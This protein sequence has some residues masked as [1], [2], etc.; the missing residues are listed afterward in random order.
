MLNTTILPTLPVP[1]IDLSMTL[2]VI[3]KLQY[4]FK[5]DTDIEVHHKT[6]P[7]SVNIIDYYYYTILQKAETVTEFGLRRSLGSSLIICLLMCSVLCTVKYSVRTD[8]QIGVVFS[9][10]ID[11]L[12]L[13]WD[14]VYSELL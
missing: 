9:R 12:W 7:A 10:K 13:D 14:I 8:L 2:K 4:C 6:E 1:E 3:D 11:C 5:K